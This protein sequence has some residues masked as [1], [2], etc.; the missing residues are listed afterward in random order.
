MLLLLLPPCI[1]WRSTKQFDDLPDLIIIDLFNYL[2]SIDVLWTFANLNHRF[3]ELV[4]E[5]GY[6]RHVNLSS[7]RLSKFDALLALLPLNQIQT[8]IIDIGASSLQLTR[9]PH[10]PSLTTL[11]LYG[12]R[13]FEDATSFI[14]QHSATL[15]HLTLGTNDRFISVCISRDSFRT[16]VPMDDIDIQLN[17]I[18]VDHSSERERRSFTKFIHFDFD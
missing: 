7:A 3:R 14:L 13:D 6:F 5:R 11:R 1:Q 12:L 8:L 15:I 18:S 9:W 17:K 2:S 4:N 10:L 16:T